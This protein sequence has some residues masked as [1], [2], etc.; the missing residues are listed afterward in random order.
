MKRPELK[1]LASLRSTLAAAEN[2]LRG[3]TD[4]PQEESA[5]ENAVTPESTT[6]SANGQPTA[7]RYDFQWGRRL[8]HGGCGIFIATS[9]L[10]Y[11]QRN[12]FVTVIG[13]IASVLY[14]LEQIRIHY[15][16]YS[17]RISFFNRY[18]LR[19]EES[20][21]ESSAFPYIMA[22]L[23][24][25]I[26]FPRPIAVAAIYAL[27]VADPLAA[28]VGIRFGRHKVFRTRKSWEGSAAFFLGTF[29]CLSLTLIFFIPA[30]VGEILAVAG[31]AALLAAIFELLPIR[32]D[33]N[34]TI[35]IFIAVELWI[36]CLIFGLRVLDIS[37][38]ELMF[39][40]S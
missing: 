26:T 7:T 6:P 20:L 12:Q 3:S 37:P 35:P 30:E 28:V 8:F 32:L 31:W 16:E 38:A 21:R 11:F 9:Y 14:L 29:V 5:A 10:L 1:I 17:E 27:A 40:S 13:A 25:I 36:L 23:L 4:A 22:I 15:P 33:D 24:T 34:L 2:S 39:L 18:L 19:A